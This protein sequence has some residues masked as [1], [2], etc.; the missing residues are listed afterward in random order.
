MAT[1][2][3]PQVSIFIVFY[4]QKMHI[5]YSRVVVNLPACTCDYIQ[6]V[7]RVYMRPLIRVYMRP[8]DPPILLDSHPLASARIRSLEL[9]LYR[10]VG[11]G[12]GYTRILLR[13]LG[14]RQQPATARP[15]RVAVHFSRSFAFISVRRCLA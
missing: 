10:M 13:S 15:T 11:T 4:K 5:S 12:G 3:I 8:P 14:P 1:V 2:H 7:V 6:Q 9:A